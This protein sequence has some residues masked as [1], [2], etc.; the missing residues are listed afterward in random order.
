MLCLTEAG[1]EDPKNQQAGMVNMEAE[2]HILSRQIFHRAGQEILCRVDGEGEEPRCVFLTC[3]FGF[4][5][6]YCKQC[7][8]NTTIQMDGI[9]QAGVSREEAGRQDPKERKPKKL[10]TTEH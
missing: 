10:K 4:N 5:I 8:L 6:C 9:L 1:A 7:L 2:I 3:S